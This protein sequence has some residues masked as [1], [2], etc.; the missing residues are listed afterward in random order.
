MASNAQAILNEANVPLEY[1]WKLLPEAAIT[2]VKLDWLSVITRG[3]VTK[4]KIEIFWLPI[5][6]FAKHLHIWGEAGT[7][8]LPKNGKVQPRGVTCVFIGYAANHKGDC[9]RMWNPMTGM[10][11]L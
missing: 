3:D 2:V 4:S 5:P 11:M 10:V 9:Y 6:H 1:R 8:K 7:V